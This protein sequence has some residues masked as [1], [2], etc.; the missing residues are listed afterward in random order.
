MDF[1]E[2]AE[3]ICL[4]P[5]WRNFLHHRKIAPKPEPCSSCWHWEEVLREAYNA[6]AKAAYEDAA[7]AL[8]GLK[9]QATGDSPRHWHAAR[10]TG[11]EDAAAYC[12]TRSLSHRRRRN[13]H[14]TLESVRGESET[15]LF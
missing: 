15:S 9:S 11:L 7:E 5:T 12:K 13:K 3:Q 10:N 8:I 6:G 2:Q 4:N 14:D 1:K